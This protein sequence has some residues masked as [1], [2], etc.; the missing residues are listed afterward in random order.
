MG[1][2]WHVCSRGNEWATQ[3][4]STGDEVRGGL[5]QEAGFGV[6][7]R[8]PGKPCT[9]CSTEQ[10]QSVLYGGTDLGSWMVRRSEASGVLLSV[11]LCLCGISQWLW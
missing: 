2:L 1:C 4:G 8:E 7:P 11:K 9:D 3:A 10:I 6:C 5:E